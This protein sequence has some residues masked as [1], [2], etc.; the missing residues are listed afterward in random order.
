MGYCFAHEHNSYAEY[1]EKKWLSSANISYM[2]NVFSIYPTL[3][4]FNRLPHFVWRF[5]RDVADVSR[6]IYLYVFVK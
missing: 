5:R 2:W 6:F 4:A 1:A 3:S